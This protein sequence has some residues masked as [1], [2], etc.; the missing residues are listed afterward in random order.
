[1]TSDFLDGVQELFETGTADI[2]Q[3]ESDPS[4]ARVVSGSSLARG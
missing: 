1:M 4:E 3:G 2:V